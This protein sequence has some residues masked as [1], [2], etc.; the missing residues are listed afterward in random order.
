MI[1]QGY[2]DLSTVETALA[3]LRH[4]ALQRT[5]AVN[6]LRY[7]AVLPTFAEAPQGDWIGVRTRDDDG[8]QLAVWHV[9]EDAILVG[10]LSD[11]Q[12][13]A[14]YM[15]AKT[16]DDFFIQRDPQG[17]LNINLAT[18]TVHGSRLQA[19]LRSVRATTR[20][21]IR[22]LRE[23]AANSSWLCANCD[24]PNEANVVQC[25]NCKT[26]TAVANPPSTRDET[27][28]PLTTSADTLF[29]DL[30]NDPDFGKDLLEDLVDQSLEELRDQVIEQQVER[31]TTALTAGRCVACRKAIADD[32]RFC[33]HC[34]APQTAPCPSCSESVS[35]DSNFCPH[36]G[37]NLVED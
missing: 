8:L 17:E 25:E 15:A 3:P 1:E 21:A 4:A 14:V 29:S 2:V 23:P 26:P 34:G 19:Y 37:T 36:C 9:A 32:A 31:A 16:Q 20:D 24:W 35:A 33:R 11:N 13:T 12:V 6:L 30:L 10:T 27:Q 5:A 7:L 22:I 28:T 18:G